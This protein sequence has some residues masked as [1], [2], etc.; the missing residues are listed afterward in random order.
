[1]KFDKTNI[2]IIL[3][4]FTSIL[5]PALVQL[6]SEN[7][8]NFTFLEDQ[9]IL[10]FLIYCAFFIVATILILLVVRLVKFLFLKKDYFEESNSLIEEVCEKYVYPTKDSHKQ[11][12]SLPESNT[13]N[14]DNEQRYR[15]GKPEMKS[16]TI[17]YSFSAK[18]YFNWIDYLYIKFIKQ[19]KD[20]LKC[21]VVIAL[22]YPD[23][24]KE[25]KIISGI[26]T[27][28]NQV[29]RKFKK[30][31]VYF[32]EIIKSIIGEDVVI[33]TENKFY[34]DGV[35]TY[36]EDFHN[37]YVSTALYYAHLIGQKDEENN[38]YTYRNF[39][40]R[41]SHIESAFPIWMMAKK[42]KHSRTYVVDNKLSQAIWDIE[43]LA[44][45]KKSGIYFIE[46]ADL[47]DPNN[48]RIDVH[49]EANVPNLSDSIEILK[50]KLERTPLGV[51]K[52]MF[53]L[54]D[55]G[56]TSL[57]GCSLP[58]SKL[59][60]EDNVEENKYYNDK[61]LELFSSLATKY[62]ITKYK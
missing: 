48:V 41:L 17:Y 39:K 30:I 15:G 22:H 53:S 43:P 11:V 5:I 10:S 61:L 12:F 16:N 50:E 21:K 44:Q 38:I 58:F 27:D 51:K 59:E 23:D 49:N 8:L 36:A 20:K 24:I 28:P 62:N 29:N 9:P 35:K 45:I 55:D 7:L 56:Q 31:C 18:E 3:F 60:N 2:K 4:V 26:N 57:K 32:S 13:I 52:M 54:L 33:K 37:V 25:C 1:M 19:L 46:V 14:H 40:R 34:L 6:I 42:N 47:C